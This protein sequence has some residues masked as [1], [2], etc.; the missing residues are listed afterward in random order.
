MEGVGTCVQLDDLFAECDVVSLHI[1]LTEETAR[2]VTPERILALPE[3]A[4]VVNVSRGELVEQP[5]VMSAFV[6]RVDVTYAVDDP[7]AEGLAPLRTRLLSTP[8]IAGIT[9]E[10]LLAMQRKVVGDVVELARDAN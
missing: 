2:L 1:P 6:R 4:I 3:G 5:A 8:H 7:P 10:A 9:G